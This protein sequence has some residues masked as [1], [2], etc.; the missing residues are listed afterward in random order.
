M[1]STNL[2]RRGGAWFHAVATSVAESDS[3]S[4]HALPLDRCWLLPTWT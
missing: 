1:Q 3:V 2:L 4:P